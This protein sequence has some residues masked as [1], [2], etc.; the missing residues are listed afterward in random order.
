[1]IPPDPH[2]GRGRPSPASNLA[3]LLGAGGGRKIFE[4]SDAESCIL[5]TSCCEIFGFLKTTAKKLGGPIHCWSTQPKIGDQSPSVPTVVRT[6]SDRIR[7]VEVCAVRTTMLQVQLCRSC[8]TI[9]KTTRWCNPCIKYITTCIDAASKRQPLQAGE[10]KRSGDQS[11]RSRRLI[12]WCTLCRLSIASVD[13]SLS[14]RYLG[15]I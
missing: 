6:H 8:W 12:P 4:N 15:G 9:A 14:V 13:R 7:L 1:M 11:R 10:A 2:S 3:T 5:V